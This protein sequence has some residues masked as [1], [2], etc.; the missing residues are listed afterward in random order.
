MAGM[1]T[2]PAIVHE[3]DSTEELMELSLIENIQREDL[4]PIEEARGYRELIDTCLLT[5]EDIARKVG[6]DPL[7]HRQHGAPS[8]A[9]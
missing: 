8:E 5:Q 9:A 1:E 2:I 7:D 3:I 6:R 4:N